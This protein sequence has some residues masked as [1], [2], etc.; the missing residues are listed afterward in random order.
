MCRRAKISGKVHSET[1]G[2]LQDRFHPLVE[3]ENGGSLTP[4]RGRPGVLE[5]ERRL[6][7][8]GWSEKDRAGAVLKTPA[9]Q[10]VQLLILRFK[11]AALLAL[12]ML[13]RDEPRENVQ[14][15]LIDDEVVIPAAVFLPAELQDAEPP[16]LGT[17]FR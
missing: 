6:P 8:A 12:D 5:G 3:G 17:V 7:A 10:G 14:P 9:Q 15:T 11:Q 13:A 2:A 4:F 1:C 16:A